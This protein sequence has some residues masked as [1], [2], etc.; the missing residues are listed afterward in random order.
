[1]I[2]EPAPEERHRGQGTIR[3]RTA[4]A[5]NAGELL[6]TAAQAAAALAAAKGG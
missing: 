5:Q 1:M 4:S 6:A 3:L 2:A